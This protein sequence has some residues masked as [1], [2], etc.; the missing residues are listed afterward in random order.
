MSFKVNWPTFSPEFL[1]KAKE[2]LQVAL[3]KEGDDKPANIV[4]SILVQELYMGTKV[5]YIT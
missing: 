4:D 2:Q 1:S 5:R 3:N